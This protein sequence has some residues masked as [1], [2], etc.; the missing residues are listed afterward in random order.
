M[1]DD[2]ES[3]WDGGDAVDDGVMN[4]FL[5]YVRLSYKDFDK[6]NLMCTIPLFIMMFCCLYI[7]I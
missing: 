2:Y 4:L 5:N 1:D 6:G 3:H 7:I